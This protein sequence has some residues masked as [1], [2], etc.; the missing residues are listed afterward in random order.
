MLLSVD[1]DLGNWWIWFPF[2]FYGKQFAEESSKIS[3]WYGAFHPKRDSRPSDSAA[4]GLYSSPSG[5]SGKN[6]VAR[7]ADRPV[8]ESPYA[9]T[10]GVIWV[11]DQ[12]S[13]SGSQSLPVCRARNNIIL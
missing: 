2:P 11:A 12:R 3:R 7:R 9:A 10:A 8:L 1:D 6:E 5:G 13:L 4:R